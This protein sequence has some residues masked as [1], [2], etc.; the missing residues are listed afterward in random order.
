[1]AEEFTV[2]CGEDIVRGI[3]TDRALKNDQLHPN[4]AGYRR[5]AGPVAALIREA[6]SR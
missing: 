4:A 3:L 5:P 6:G 2:P 1:L